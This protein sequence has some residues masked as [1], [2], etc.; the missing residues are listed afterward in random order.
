VTVLD[1]SAIGEAAEPSAAAGRG[2][3]KVI[4]VKSSSQRPRLLSGVVR[5]RRPGKPPNHLRWVAP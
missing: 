3:M 5:G 2:R 4:R 1:M